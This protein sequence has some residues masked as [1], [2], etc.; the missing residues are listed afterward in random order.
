MNKCASNLRLCLAPAPP[1]VPQPLRALAPED[2]SGLQAP[3]AAAI[4]RR[5][6][7]EFTL[8]GIPASEVAQTVLDSIQSLGKAWYDGW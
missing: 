6:G 2:T 1:A 4:A 8:T 7:W 5:A 3:L